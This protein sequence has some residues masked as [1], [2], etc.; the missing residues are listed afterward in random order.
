MRDDFA[1][2]ILS[3]GRS[4][5]L[6]TLK[7]LNTLEYTGKYYII[8][9]NE[10]DTAQEYYNRFGENHV[11]MFDKLAISKTF[12]TGDTFGDRRTICYARN[13]CFAI[14]RK[15]NLKY[16]IELDDDYVRFEERWVQKGDKKL[17]GRSIKRIDEV[18]EA[19]IDFLN[20][21][22]AITVCF[23]QGGDFV[24][25]VNSLAAKNPIL[26]KAMNTFICDV[27]KPF[28]FVGRINEDVNTYTTLGQRGALM[29][30]VTQI[31][32]GQ[33]AT[34]SN[35]K[36]MSD[37]YLANGTYL[38]SFYSVMYSPSCVKIGVLQSKHMRIHHQVNWVACTPKIINERWK[39]CP[40]KNS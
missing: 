22:N 15:L 24:G 28:T 36:G 39:K 8:I 34:Q 14:A 7:T 37:V 30:T 18:L 35:K 27:D 5:V 40:Q 6:C 32:I 31:A 25:G 29:M 4:D 21:T 17:R 2:F 33:K 23:A 9:D 38:K 10:D 16:F 13:A 1:V 19:M 3:H 20:D 12:D 11:I 26:R